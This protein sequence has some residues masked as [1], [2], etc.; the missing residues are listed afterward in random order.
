MK[1]ARKGQCSKCKN[2]FYVHQ[3]HI[4][5]KSIFG[6][7]GETADLCPNCHTHFHEFSKQHTQN[8]KDAGEARELW[9]IWLTTV[10]VTCC[11]LLLVF[12]AARLFF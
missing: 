5:P 8:P 2:Y 4:L 3:H 7:K 9:N 6:K 12:F 1:E 11:I 10:S